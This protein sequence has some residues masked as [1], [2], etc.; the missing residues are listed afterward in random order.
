M[1][2]V[3]VT[4]GA[5]G[6]GAAI[7]RGFVAEGARVAVCD[8]DAEAVRAFG[9]ANPQV[10]AIQADVAVPAAVTAVTTQTLDALGGLD[11]LVNNAGVPGPTAPVDEV[12]IDEWQRVLAVNLT[13][14]FL[15]IRA[16]TGLFKAQRH[17]CIIN[18]STT[19]TRHVIPFRTPYVAS[20]AGLEGLSGSVARELGPYGVR[21]IV[22]APG[23]VDNERTCGVIARL[24]KARG[25]SP[26]AME[27][28]LLRFISLRRKIEMREIADVCVFLASDR[29]AAMS[30][31]VIAVDGNVEWEG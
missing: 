12:G 29:A 18:I 19:S 8:I 1:R 3:L 26:Q 24:A 10:L 31:Q 7:A 15:F 17:G 16:L 13:G 5:N 28:E 25:L 21:S 2:R 23:F 4:A 11:V 30:G 9:R 20:K 27:A 14:P 22:V 6:I